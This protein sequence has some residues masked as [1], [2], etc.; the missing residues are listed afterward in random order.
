MKARDRQNLN[1]TPEAVVAMNLWGDR[2]CRQNGGSMDFWES[3][4][5]RDK[6]RCRDIVAGVVGALAN[7][8][9]SR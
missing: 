2:Y 8:N 4:P 7:H 6:Q 3:L 9:R 1:P 5:E